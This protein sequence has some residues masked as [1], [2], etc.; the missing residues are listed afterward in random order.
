MFQYP[1]NSEKDI[2]DLIEEIKTKIPDFTFS[3]EN[4][5]KFKEWNSEDIEFLSYLNGVGG[6]YVKFLSILMRKLQPQLTVELWNREWVSTLWMA[7]SAISF[8]WKFIT[9]DIV[10]DLRYFPDSLNDEKKNIFTIF[11]DVFDLNTYKEIPLDIDL[12]FSDT[13]HYND[14]IRDEFEIYQYLLSDIALVAIDDIHVNDKWIFFDQID[15]PKWDLT[16]LCHHS[17][18]W[19]FL[20]QRREPLTREQRVEKALRASISVYQRRYQ[21]F[22][23]MQE[24]TTQNSISFRAMKSLRK[25]T[26]YRLLLPSYVHIYK[27]LTWKK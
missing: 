11:G 26:L 20:F 13:I 8:G 15:Y 23:D 5:I 14:Q 1:I 16:Q 7:E 17:G 2:E 6:S 22:V 4:L 9:V 12:L 25:T 21:H 10:H 18:W 24:F 27:V 3:K 19:L